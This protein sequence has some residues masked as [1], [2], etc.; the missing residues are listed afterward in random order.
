MST[1]IGSSLI[2][3]LFPTEISDGF[4]GKR[5][6]IQD[7]P[8][9]EMGL[10]ERIISQ[11]TWREHYIS[12]Q[13][14]MIYLVKDSLGKIIGVKNPSDIKIF[15]WRRRT[16]GTYKEPACNSI[17]SRLLCENKILTSLAVILI[18]IYFYLSMRTKILIY[19]WI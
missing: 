18:E 1:L 4:C 11:N 9:C 8:V 10:K 13:W 17:N 6:Q 19:I 14:E 16:T 7:D 15:D 5:V 2:W 12:R 3:C